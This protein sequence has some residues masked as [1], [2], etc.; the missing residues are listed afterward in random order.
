[1]DVNIMDSSTGE[2]TTA[3]SPDTMEELPMAL[4]NK[5]SL[6]NDD[7]TSGARS[8]VEASHGVVGNIMELNIEDKTGLDSVTA[9]ENHVTNSEGTAPREVETRQENQRRK[10]FK[11][12]KLKSTSYHMKSK[13]M[14]YV[15]GRMSNTATAQSC[16]REG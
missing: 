6:D 4:D 10:A 11:A 5:E 14:R 2:K 15:V 9:T 12:I 8:L 7:A 16:D 13:R 3:N 1:M